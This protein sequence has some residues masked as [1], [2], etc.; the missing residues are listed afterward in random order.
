[1]GITPI[2]KA[3]RLA[4]ERNL[5][6]VVVAPNADPPVC[7]L[8]DYGKYEY[9]RAKRM[10][11]ARKAQKQ[12]EIK[13]IRLRPR[14]DTHDLDFKVRDAR[15]FLAKGAKVKIRVRFRGREITH[16]E[17]ARK[18]L[19]TLA[20]K[21]QDEAVVEK[22][23]AFEGKSLLMILA[24]ATHTA[25]AKSKKPKPRQPKTARSLGVDKV[26]D[27]SREK[28]AGEAKTNQQDD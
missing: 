9:E 16:P 17:I 12:V 6:L 15:R 27:K 5:D 18:V 2:A 25:K 23:P 28:N 11:E 13:E 3:K 22:P 10:R 8:M 24:P 14:T 26:T 4:R 20:E 7:R 1:M 19:R 21:L